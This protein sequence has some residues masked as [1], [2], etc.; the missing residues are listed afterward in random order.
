MKRCRVSPLGIWSS[1]NIDRAVPE[2]CSTGKVL[3]LKPKSAPH[4]VDRGIFWSY[5]VLILVRS[6]AV[7]MW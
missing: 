1:M 2:E 7:L 3:V 6:P 5:E 4:C